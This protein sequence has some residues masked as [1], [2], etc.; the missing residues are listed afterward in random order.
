M[1]KITK[2]LNK[3]LQI[4]QQK[5][6]DDEIYQAFGIAQCHKHDMN[7]ELIKRE[8]AKE[9]GKYVCQKIRIG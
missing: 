6:K 5:Y 2:L 8:L 7:I 9:M 4:F 3:L 1:G